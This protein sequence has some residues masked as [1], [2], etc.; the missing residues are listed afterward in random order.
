MDAMIW[1]KAN[2]LVNGRTLT[3]L[4]PLG[5]ATRAEAAAIFQ[6]FLENIV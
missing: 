3:T 4:V 2:G 1:A 6:R 5:T